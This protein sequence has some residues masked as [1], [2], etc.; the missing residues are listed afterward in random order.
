MRGDAR[1][2]D[3]GVL[4]DFLEPLDRATAL[5]GLRSAQT[6]QVP[7]PADLRR[8]HEARSDEPVL[9]ELADP[10]RVLHIGLAAGDNQSHRL[11]E[12]R[13]S[14]PAEVMVMAGYHP[15]CGE[16][17]VVEG[18]RRVGGVPCLIVRLADGTPG[19]VEVQA[20][21]AGATASEPAAGAL[22]SAEGVRRLRRLLA[23]GSAGGE[24]SG[25]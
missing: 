25:T 1:E 7:Q 18:R 3:P 2:L 11:H 5:V 4:Q 16:R 9:H 10:L 19:M 24:G 6:G 23:P 20:T 13:S 15:L 21:S 17:L 14:L 8:R 22:L 12:L